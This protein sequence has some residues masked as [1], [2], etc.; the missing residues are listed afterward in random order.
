MKRIGPALLLSFLLSACGGGSSGGPTTAP[1]VL[2]VE[3]HTGSIAPSTLGCNSGDHTF[4]AR[5][6]TISVRL[7]ATSAADQS[8][9]AQICAGADVAGQCTISQQRLTVGQTLSGT[10]VGAAGQTLKLLR[11]DCVSSAQQ[12]SAPVTYSTTLT[13]LK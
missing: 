9:S 13:Y 3:T 1:A 2:T 5:E 11:Q 8:V 6:G 12:A 10:R 4:T 7:D